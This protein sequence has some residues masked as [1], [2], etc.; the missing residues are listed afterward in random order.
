MQFN[1]VAVRVFSS[2]VAGSHQFGDQSW[3]QISNYSLKLVQADLGQAAPFEQVKILELSNGPADSFEDWRQRTFS[4]AELADPLI[5]GAQASPFGDGT[6]NLLRHAF[7]VPSGE[8]AS[9]YLPGISSGG[10]GVGVE[11]PYDGNR[12]DIRVVVESS[13]TLDDWTGVVVLFDSG[14][15]SP[16]VANELGRIRIVDSRPEVPSRFYRV[17]VVQ[18]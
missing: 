13:D 2:D 15:D 16:P 8:D 1:L 7:G 17:R 14:L 6:E 3:N 12:D 18:D 5:S 4:A 10:S 11:F 9:G